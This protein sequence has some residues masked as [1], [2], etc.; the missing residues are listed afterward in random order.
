M[1]YHYFAEPPEAHAV[2]NLKLIYKSF[3]GQAAM[4]LAAPGLQGFDPERVISRFNLPESYVVLVPSNSHFKKAH[5]LNHRAW[6]L[7]HWRSLIDLLSDKGYASVLIGAASDSA[8]VDEIGPLPTNCINLVG[9]TRYSEV[10]TL[11]SAASHVI[12]TD[13]GPA[14]IAAATNTPVTVLIGP[15]NPRRTGPF[16]TADN[17][18]ITL[19]AGLPCS[20]CYH[21]PALRNCHYNRCMTQIRPLDVVNA[22]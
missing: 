21:T 13:T 17:K 4:R 9:K 10:I 7:E 12:A 11:I 19:S 1:P 22:I 14:H 16:E 15:T 5:P 3:L 6:P 8:I 18:V 20:P 2:E